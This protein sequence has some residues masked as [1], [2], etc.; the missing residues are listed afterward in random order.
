M[1]SIVIYLFMHL[2]LFS[3]FE[4]K[5]HGVKETFSLVIDAQSPSLLGPLAAD[6]PQL[7]ACFSDGIRGHGDKPSKD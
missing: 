2:S 7:R 1:G 5:L 6:N 4:G 3:P